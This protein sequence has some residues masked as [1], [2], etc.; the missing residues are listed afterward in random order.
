LGHLKE[1]LEHAE[2]PQMQNR[3]SDDFYKRLLDFSQNGK[4]ARGAIFLYTS[5]MFGHEVDKDL[6][7]LASALE[8]IQGSLLIHDDIMDNDRM[9]RN[10]ETIFVQYENVLKEEHTDT[11]EHTGVSLAI[12]MG[13]VCFFL[14]NYFVTQT[15]ISPEIKSALIDLISKELIE[16][17]FAQMYDCV[18]TVGK[19]DSED[20]ILS[21][22][23]YKA[24]RYTFSLPLMMAAIVNKQNKE[25]VDQLSLLGEYIGVLYQIHDE[26]L[27]L[28]GKEEEIGKPVGTDIREDR[29]TLYKTYL[30]ESANDEERKQLNDTFGNA[31]VTTE[32]I[33]FIKKMIHE[34]NVDT[35][36][37]DLIKDYHQK[38][39]EIINK[40]PATEE[41]KKEMGELVDFIINRTS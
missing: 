35:K 20:Q 4:A 21:L 13:D 30:Y 38:S 14:A 27:G 15:N 29:K 2:K 25:V 34:K 8:V 19:Y 1:L 11:A 6:L 3:W 40:L 28:Y 32:N 24:A 36:V 16:V 39:T 17:G 22:Y 33:E 7:N 5:K 18:N 23:K 31:S 37:K 26:E 9:R 41:Y 10:K 12:C